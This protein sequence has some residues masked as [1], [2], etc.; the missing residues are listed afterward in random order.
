MNPPI[1]SFQCQMYVAARGSMSFR[2][3]SESGPTPAAKLVPLPYDELADPGFRRLLA[4][5]NTITAVTAG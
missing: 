4:A 2:L 5:F 3:P 1:H